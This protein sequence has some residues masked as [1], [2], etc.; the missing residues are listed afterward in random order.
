MF[1]WRV[2]ITF[3]RLSNAVVSPYLLLLLYA[4]LLLRPSLGKG[5]IS[6]CISRDTKKHCSIGQSHINYGLIFKNNSFLTV[7]RLDIFYLAWIL[8]TFIN[9]KIISRPVYYLYTRK[10]NFYHLFQGNKV[11][12]VIQKTTFFVVN[13]CILLH[14]FLFRVSY[15]WT[16]IYIISHLR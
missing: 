1:Y 2:G 16:C 11:I 3:F 13:S 14:F 10:N 7:L 5:R 9:G 4:F 12:P 6:T 15:F 8:L